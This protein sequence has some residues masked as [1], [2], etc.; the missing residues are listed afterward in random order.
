[1]QLLSLS[2]TS[3]EDLYR[4]NMSR[5]GGLPEEQSR[6]AT[7]ALLWLVF[8]AR[9]L[10]DRELGH[11]LAVN[12]GSNQFDK[13]NIP[14]TRE[15]LALCEGFVVHVE[16]DGLLLLVHESAHK[17]LWETLKEW[18][19]EA[20]G[21]IARS[22]MTYLNLDV[23]GEGFCESDEKLESRLNEF[24]FYSYAARNWGTH[25]R[26][27]KHLPQKEILS[28]LMN[29]SK[30]DFASQVMQIPVQRPLQQNYSQM[31]TRQVT[32]LHLAAYW[33]LTTV[34]KWLLEEGQKP[35]VKDSNNRTPLWQAT[36][37]GHIEAMKLL[38]VNDL[39]T[40]T[41]MLS[42]GK[43]NPAERNLA[44]ALLYAARSTIRDLR[45]GSALHITIRQNDLQM[46][47][48]A[49]Q[50]GVDV[51]SEDRH[52]ITPIKLALQEKKTQAV[53]L[54]LKHSASTADIAI[55]DWSR[56]YR[57]ESTEII[58]LYQDESG[59][60]EVNF[61]ALKDFEKEVKCHINS[62]RRLFVFNDF[63][64]WPENPLFDPEVSPSEKMLQAKYTPTEEEQTYSILAAILVP[65]T[66]QFG[67]PF[68]LKE[69]Y[70]RMA[71]TMRVVSN[72]LDPTPGTWVSHDHFCT[73]QT[74]S[75]PESGAQFLLHLIRFIKK[76]W[77]EFCDSID[78]HLLECRPQV[79]RANGEDPDL[80]TRLLADA[81]TWS[82]L[83]RL[84]KTQVE[85]AKAFRKFYIKHQYEDYAL[86]GVSRAIDNLYAAIDYRIDVFDA[87]SRDLI[88]LEFNLTSIREAKKSTTIN[89]SLKR[90]TAVTFLF[91][92]LMFTSTLFG[93]N[94]DLLATNPSCWW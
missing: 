29:P 14:E 52:G 13:Q 3:L 32:G 6:L 51:D 15:I 42:E 79:H 81:N 41:R 71:W 73:F 31:V 39:T 93:M 26:E 88:Q 45:F 22:C 69:E 83:R 68:K 53:D 28:F 21:T 44:M 25:L 38:S 46:M 24:V 20:R 85:E 8:A 76:K 49:L 40:F 56:V 58:V 65:G 33:G 67:K 94:I 64:S 87:S 66:L 60:T 74:C 61:I 90:L 78:C 19:P 63:A 80:I 43:N 62:R 75:V 36:A 10:R 82:D 77:M 89:R 55:E 34:I 92:P 2:V 37:S 7:T 12:L 84:L 86:D 70:V 11:V 5:I 9:P 17:Y 16:P 47:E 50:Y 4:Q 91:L 27:L 57:R 35:S 23:F 54:L 59:T 30:V 18:A 72:A 48:L 1:M